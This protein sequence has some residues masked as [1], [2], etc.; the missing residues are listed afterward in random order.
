MLSAVALLGGCIGAPIDH[1]ADYT[2]QAGADGVSS[3]ELPRQV[4]EPVDPA[5][6]P[7]RPTR[8]PPVVT[9][10]PGTP[11]IYIPT[12][13]DLQLD[14]TMRFYGGGTPTLGLQIDVTNIGNAPAYGPS[15]RV[16]INGVVLSGALYQ[17]Y[18]GSATNQPNTVNPNEHGYIKVEVPTY[19]MAACQTYAVQIDLD[20][21]MQAGDGNPFANDSGNVSTTC[22]L[23]W[24][25]PIDTLHL[26]HAPDPI[27]AGKSLQDIVSSVVSGRADGLLCS[28]CHNAQS[29][30]NFAY[31]PNVT[32]GVASAPIDP[33][34][35]IG[36]D[37]GWACGGN[38]WARQFIN[39]P[40]SVYVKPEYL[41]DAFNKWLN[42][43]GT[44]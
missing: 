13:S 4:I 31:R 26:G 24:S 35:F 5:P 33:F 36:G 17:Y 39:L 3:N 1:D 43:G 11:V 14:G 34:M 9:L 19:L 25:T 18:G 42:D 38:P 20:H 15:G 16:S 12:Y 10:P 32:P 22:A 23:G 44:R 7:T 37:E 40:A 27:I 21:T 29:G 8:P 41:K 28:T 6:A 30:S 2:D